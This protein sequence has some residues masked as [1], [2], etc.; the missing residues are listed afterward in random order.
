VSHRSVR[1]RRAR[2]LACY[3][4]DGHLVVENYLTGQRS[5]LPPLAADVLTYC[6]RPR[7]PDDVV[8]AFGEYP[9][10][11]VRA[12]LGLLTKHT[13]LEPSRGIERTRDPLD[14]WR[15]WMPSGAFFHFATKNAHYGYGDLM[16]H[17]LVRKAKREPPPAKI[18][19]YPGAARTSLPPAEEGSALARVL[20]ERRT[21]RRFAP[22]K[23]LALEDVATLLRLTWGVQRWARTEL[24]KA[25]LKTSPSGGARH[26]IEAYLL[27]RKVRGLAPGWYH[28]DAE[29][30]ALELVQVHQRPA[31]PITYLPSQTAY[32]TAP[33]LFVM[34]AVFA[35]TQW[36]YGNARAYRVVLI[37]AGHLGQTFCLVAT[38][39][40]LAPF[41][42]A[43]IADAKVER[44]LSLDGVTESVIYACGAGVRPAGVN[45]AP[46]P[47]DRPLPRLYLPKSRTKG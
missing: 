19:R 10:R 3:W 45:W 37:D 27:A 44:D 29:S 24:G 9:D 35:R 42:S 30:H 33:A 28:Y 11:S 13:L 25:A 8:R 41:C 2:P 18:K 26:P 22:R 47:D 32:R 17:E 34:S 14:G 15:A 21:W 16:R 12:L 1:F 36:A 38:A 5:I 7:T 39:L 23:L 40:G 43:A 6:G 20:R 46:W 31:N 4:H